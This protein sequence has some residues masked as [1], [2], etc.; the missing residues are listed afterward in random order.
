[1][2]IN[3]LKCIEVLMRYLVNGENLETEI[4]SK[5]DRVKDFE[6]HKNNLFNL[7]SINNLVSN[8]SKNPSFSLE[9]FLNTGIIPKMYNEPTAI[10]STDPVYYTNCQ[11]FYSNLIT[12]LKENNYVFDD[13]NNVFVSSTTL[14]ATIPEIWLYRLSQAVKREKYDKLFMYSKKRTS[15]KDKNEL[16]EYLRTTKTFLVEL[17]ASTPNPNYDAVYSA[18]EEKVKESAKSNK[19]NKV[20][21]MIDLFKSSIPESY[22]TK[23]N[24]YRINESYWI[25]KKAEEMGDAFYSAPLKFQESLISEWVT[26]RINC[27]TK[28]AEEAQKFILLTNTSGSKYPIDKLNKK[29]ILSG[30]FALYIRILSTIEHD[31]SNISLSDFKIKSYIDEKAQSSKIDRRAIDREINI[32]N[33]KIDELVKEALDIFEDIK[34]MDLL[35]E[36]DGISVKRIR[37]NRLTDLINKYK[38]E[39][40]KLEHSKLEL[41][42]V[43]SLAFDNDRIMELLTTSSESGQVYVDASNIIAELYNSQISD[44]IFKVSI[45]IKRLLNFIEDLNITLEEYGYS[46]R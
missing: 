28:S 36:F 42:D 9:T 26:E 22:N 32:L 46:K 45:N 7:I 29:E 33:T 3:E 34:N 16:Q 20:D 35:T 14:E 12:A 40:E 15:I 39:K 24:K 5:F 8:F 4:S 11:E 25:I 13:D 41:N 27:N 37:Y 30:L 17:T 44:P 31:L 43:V 23:I 19:V 2:L 18:S 10:P 6:N 1:M 21:N 38:D